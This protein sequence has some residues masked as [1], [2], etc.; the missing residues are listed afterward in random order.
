M[1]KQRRK[2]RTVTGRVARRLYDAVVGNARR[3]LDRMLNDRE[4]VFMLVCAQAT[5]QGL[6]PVDFDNDQ[7]RDALEAIFLALTPREHDRKVIHVT[8]TWRRVV[9]SARDIRIV[10]PTSTG[11]QFAGSDDDLDL[12]TSS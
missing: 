6:E 9:I 12:R 11:W 1:K 3:P 7:G 2:P 4:A 10:T 8:P 5:R